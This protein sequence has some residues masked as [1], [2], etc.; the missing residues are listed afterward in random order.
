VRLLVVHAHP[1][2]ESFSAAL[3]QAVLEG[4]A[5]GGHDC[6]LI[7]L[8][9]EGFDP[10]MQ[11]AEWRAFETGQTRLPGDAHLAWAE[12][13]VLVYPTWWQGPP[14]MLKGWIERHWRPGLAFAVEGGQMR[15]LLPLKLLAVVTT[16]GAPNW[17]VAQAMA[18]V[19]RRVVLGGLG[20]AAQGGARKMWLSLH[21]AQNPAP[22]RHARFAARVR[23]TFA[24]LRG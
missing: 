6:R 18:L 13:V 9:A 12:G 1:A 14:A 11:A 22:G 24:Q 3:C 20:S 17:F 8:Y 10:S 21:D 16:F 5:E 23:R 4:A 19:G 15:P 2:P 7:D